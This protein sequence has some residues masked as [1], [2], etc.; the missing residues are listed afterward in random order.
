MVSLAFQKVF[1]TQPNRNSTF[2][3]KAAKKFSGKNR[4]SVYFFE[5][6]NL[7]RRPQLQ[8]LCYQIEQAPRWQSIFSG[9]LNREV[10]AGHNNRYHHDKPHN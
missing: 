1:K 2:M 4:T 9:R 7:F 3:C 8:L 10:H 6:I 5:K